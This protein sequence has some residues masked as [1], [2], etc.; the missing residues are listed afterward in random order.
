M[1]HLVLERSLY[2]SFEVFNVGNEFVD[3]SIDVQELIRKHWPT[4]PCDV[5][6]NE[7]LYSI[8]KAKRLLGY[9]PVC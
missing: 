5:S 3:D 7:T 2:R 8:E 6:D 1:L 9:R 4:V